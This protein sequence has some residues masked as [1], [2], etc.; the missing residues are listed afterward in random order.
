MLAL[1]E[2]SDLQIKSEPNLASQASFL[3]LESRRSTLD[4]TRLSMLDTNSRTVPGI[5]V[6]HSPTASFHD[7]CFRSSN[8]TVK[9]DSSTR[10]TWASWPIS[11]TS[12]I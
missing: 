9:S 2:L 4:E 5:E 10:G 7:P 1:H 6:I 11:Q 8:S 12:S 3:P